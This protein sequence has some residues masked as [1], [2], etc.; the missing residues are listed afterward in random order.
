MRMGF[1]KRYLTI[2]ILPVLSFL[3]IIVGVLGFKQYRYYSEGER[4]FRQN[5]Y[6]RATDNYAM[7]LY[8]HIPMSPLETKSINRL[9]EI[10]ELFV[11]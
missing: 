9:L 5:D 4:Y 10:G 11:C 3:V 2:A 1:K 7:V 6:L 8:M